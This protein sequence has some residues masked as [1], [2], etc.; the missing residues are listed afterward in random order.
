RRRRWIVVGAWLG[1]LAAPGGGAETAPGAAPA[2]WRG[3]VEVSARSDAPP[4]G[5]GREEHRE[6]LELLLKPLPAQGK[7]LG[8]RRLRLEDGRGTWRLRV[9]TREPGGSE[10]DVV[11]TKGA[12][13]GRLHAHVAGW[14]HPASGAFR[15][16]IGVAP[17][18]LRVPVDLS[19]FEDGRLKVFHTVAARKSYLRR[20]VIEGRLTGERDRLSGE[21]SFVDRSHRLRREVQARWSFERVDPVIR[22]RVTDAA[23]RP[24]AGVLVRARTT[25]PARVRQG[26]P[27]LWREGRT[28]T[29]GRFRIGAFPSV[30]LLHVPAVSIEAAGR[31]L[32]VDGH[33]VRQGVRITAQEV[34]EVEVRL[35]AY[36]LAAL[37]HSGR[38]RT[39]FGGDVKRYLDWVR[40]RFP[41]ALD[42]ARRRRDTAPD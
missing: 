21:R 22:G 28:D 36:R 19:G 31:V 15:I 25:T 4:R 2:L 26:L 41:E 5:T 11:A 9:R 35:D 14:I 39:R 3:W 37:P 27:P 40:A 34:P 18:S 6:R 42:R 17:A 38:L 12:A 10:G 13:S 33:V 1:S 8:R 24:L 20:F 29:L 7:D 30:W 32:L 16:E 23:G